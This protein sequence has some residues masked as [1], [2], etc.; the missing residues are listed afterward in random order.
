V[1]L[2]DLGSVNGTLLNGCRVQGAVR[3]D[4]GDVVQVGTVSLKFL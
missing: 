2:R 3:L 4:P 1:W